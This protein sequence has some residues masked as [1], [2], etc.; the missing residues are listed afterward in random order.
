[1]YSTSNSRAGRLEALAASQY[2][3]A[4]GRHRSELAPEPIHVRAVQTAGTRKQSR[5]ID[6]VRRAALVDVDLDI[7]IQTNQGSRNARMIEMDVREDD[8]PDIL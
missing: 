1:M 2:L 5:R 6:H 3:H 4:V 8:L 7:R